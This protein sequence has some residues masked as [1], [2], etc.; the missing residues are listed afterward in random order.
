MV[1]F[2][3]AKLD[4]SPAMASGGQTV[5]VKGY[6]VVTVRGTTWDTCR[7]A[8]GTE[9]VPYYLRGSMVPVRSAVT[10]AFS[11]SVFVLVVVHAVIDS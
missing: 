9:M 10:M 5:P 8:G 1:P 11:T 3:I 7:M 4:V 2:L 6:P